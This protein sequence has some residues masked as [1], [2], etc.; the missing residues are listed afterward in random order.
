V[1][2]N[3][4]F[5]LS[6]VLAAGAWLM[7]PLRLGPLA[8]P[9]SAKLLLPPFLFVTLMVVRRIRA[10]EKGRTPPAPGISAKLALGTSVVF[11][12]LLGVEQTF[13]WA[14]YERYLSPVRIQGATPDSFDDNP[15]LLEDPDLL[16]KFKPGVE[17]RGSMINEMGFLGPVANPEKAADAARLICM[18]DSVSAEGAPPYSAYLHAL[19]TNT[20]P[21]ARKWEAFNMA[22]HGYSSSQGLALLNTRTVQLNPDVVVFMYGWNDHFLAFATDKMRMAQ[23]LKSQNSSVHAA[24]INILRK[25]RF[26]QFLLSTIG[27]WKQF[28]V[29]RNQEGLRVS[30]E[31]YEYNIRQCMR[32][33]REA[34]ATPIAM[35][36]P[37]AAQ[38][39]RMLVHRAQI[40]SVEEGARLHDA[41]NDTVRRVAAGE[42]CMLIDLASVFADEEYQAFFSGDGIHFADD[43]ARKRIA[44]HIHDLLQT[45]PEFTSISTECTATP[46]T[47]PE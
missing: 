28:S 30:P 6:V 47:A 38:I 17:F 45:L 18:G 39:S 29:K 8:L 16:Y 37:R 24:L 35:T 44:G 23:K 25:K 36:S 2:L 13:E 14:G 32:R 46:R 31:E 20:P 43:E 26:G 27:P 42:K 34:G 33:I 19:L 22:V 3:L 9:W 7:T 5:I 1:I 41:Y 4:V 15:G 21:D 10:H 11:C 12:L 40:T